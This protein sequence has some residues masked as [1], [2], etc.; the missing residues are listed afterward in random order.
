MPKLLGFIFRVRFFV[1]GAFEGD[2]DE[3]GKETES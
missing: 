3:K 1:G 2:G